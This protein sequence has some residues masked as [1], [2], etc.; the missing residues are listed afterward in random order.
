[1][2][3]GETLTEWQAGGADEERPANSREKGMNRVLHILEFLHATQRAIGIGELAK[4]VNAPRSTTY[5]LVRDLVDAG[6]LEMAGDGNRVYFGKKL[7]L[8]GMAYM[9]GN[10]LLRRGRQEVDTLSRETGETSELCMLQSGRYTI[11][12]SS[13]GT[14]PFRISSATGLQI[15]LPW[16]ASGRL[17]LA[18]LDRSRIEAMISDGDLVLPDGRKLSLDDFIDD[19]GRARVAGYCVTSGL[20]DA[21]TKC[22]AAPVFSAPGKVEATM[23]LVVPIDTSEERTGELVALL[24]ERAARLSIS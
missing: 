14:R 24:R 12:H 22:L 11:V 8:Y 16:T 18:G 7:Y 6:L 23:C 3:D 13:P 17:L 2:Q 19:I 21:Y 15:P 20:V 9:R 1:M 4:G 10:D 5:T